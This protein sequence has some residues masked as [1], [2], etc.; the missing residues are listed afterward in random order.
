MLELGVHV[1]YNTKFSIIA[2]D[3]HVREDPF[4]R[5]VTNTDIYYMLSARDL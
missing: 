5:S 2:N 4:V 3:R 1:Y